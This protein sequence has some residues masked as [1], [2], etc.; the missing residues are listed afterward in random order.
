MFP[1]LLASAVMPMSYDPRTDCLRLLR[2]NGYKPA[3]ALLVADR[4]FLSCYS[5]WNGTDNIRFWHHLSSASS[6]ATFS[7]LCRRRP[8]QQRRQ[9]PGAR[10]MHA[11]KRVPRGADS[12]TSLIR[13]NDVLG[14]ARQRPTQP[15]QLRTAASVS[16]VTLMRTLTMTCWLAAE[17]EAPSGDELA[18]TSPRGTWLDL[19]SPT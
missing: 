15:L 5:T 17:N 16:C 11:S 18:P 6:R 19:N 13:C 10:A 12:A 3:T 14:H 9:Q 8:R 1:S 4:K 2:K 7:L